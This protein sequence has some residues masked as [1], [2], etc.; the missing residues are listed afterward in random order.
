MH[1][2]LRVYALYER[3]LQYKIREAESIKD[4]TIL[5]TTYSIR[6]ELFHDKLQKFRHIRLINNGEPLR[7]LRL[8]KYRETF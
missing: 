2:P 7:N 6:F 1:T 4:I 5:N 3:C 8:Q